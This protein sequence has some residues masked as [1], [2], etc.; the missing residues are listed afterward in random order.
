MSVVASFPDWAKAQAAPRFT[1]WLRERTGAAWAGATSHRFVD[2]LAQGTLPNEAFRRYLIQ[3]YAF[4]ETLVTVVGYAVAYAPGMDAKK[5]WSGF[6]GVLT[7]DENDYFQ[8]SFEALDVPV[9]LQTDVSLSPVTDALRAAMLDAA[10]AGTY[11]DVLAVIVPA[12]WVYL[13]W[14]SERRDSD[15]GPAY[16][17]EWIEL[18]AIPEFQAFVDWLRG[19]LD[20]V[21]PMLGDD[22]RDR[23]ERRFSEIVDLE[24]RFFEQAYPRS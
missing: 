11:A 2:E 19:Q 17:S 20:E 7:S 22:V 12:E 10:T 6:L 18:H 16:F 13:T 5:V 3:D 15:P 14:A 1:D 8:R 21:G 4:I 9:E 23:I 24:I